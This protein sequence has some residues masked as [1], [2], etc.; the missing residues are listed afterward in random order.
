MSDA[1]A[2]GGDYGQQSGPEIGE[3]ARGHLAAYLKTDQQEEKRKQ[4]LGEPVANRQRQRRI[5]RAD[6]KAGCDE[7][8]IDAG[9]RGVCADQR[10]C[11]SNEEHKAA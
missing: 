5:R 10:Q 3:G 7:R 9:E 1:A 8:V 2:D 11:R 4:P 6:T